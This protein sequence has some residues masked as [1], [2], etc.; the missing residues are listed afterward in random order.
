[1]ET[2]GVTFRSKA[3]TELAVGEIML[4][5]ALPDAGE[6]QGRYRLEFRQVLA[7]TP[8]VQTFFQLFGGHESGR[9]DWALGANGRGPAKL[10]F[11][12]S[13]VDSNIVVSAYQR[14]R[15]YW[16]GRWIYVTFTGSYDGGG[17]DISRKA[18]P[19]SGAGH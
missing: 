8:D 4:S 17:V 13:A 5:S 1:V 2:Y 7:K 14:A 15:G 6:V 11:M 9:V 12:P 19:A 18:T 16:S 10:D 3:G